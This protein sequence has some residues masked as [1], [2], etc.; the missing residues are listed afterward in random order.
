MNVSVSVIIPAYNAESFVEQAIQSALDQ[1]AQPMEILII[2]D[3]STDRT[4]EL[5]QRFGDPVRVISI[6]NRG[7]AGARNYALHHAVGKYVAFLDSDD[8]WEP[9]KL[10]RQCA[11]LTTERQLI[12][13]DTIS[14]GAPEMEGVR[15]SSGRTL[16][17]GRILEALV[18]GNFIATSSVLTDRALALSV[19]GFSLEFQ[20][21]E[22]WMLW[23]ALARLT[24]AEYID[25]PLVRYRIRPGSLSSNLDERVACETEIIDRTVDWLDSLSLT[26]RKALRRDA[27]ADA[28]AYAA[29]L[30]LSEG[31]L[32]HS[33]RF[34]S[35]SFATKPTAAAAK[36]YLK[37]LPGF[38]WAHICRALFNRP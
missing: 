24:G 27:I 23:L 11:L 16:P 8:I 6:Q 35:R 12:Y 25:A 22:D 36:L 37:T 32:R 3:G 15:M 34:S 21:G 2:D 18:R 4:A 29:L 10:E 9:T 30:A 38:H 17:S 13:T 33:R 19:G 5:A 1:T 28:E 14:F 7:V 20:I 26:E 31:K